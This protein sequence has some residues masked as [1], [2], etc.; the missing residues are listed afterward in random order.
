MKV[1]FSEERSVWRRFAVEF[2]VGLC[3]VLALLGWR[4]ILGGKGALALAGGGL[5]GVALLWAL[6]RWNRAFYRV[7]L[8]V[9]AAVGRVIGPV[10]LALL[11]F[12]VVTPVG[13][14]LRLAGRDLLQLRRDPAAPSYWQKARRGG[15]FEKMF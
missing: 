8:T 4:G 3:L 1:H 14:L 6:P 2:W 13:I 5:A 15:G 10:L 9:G 7:V 12:L 11:F